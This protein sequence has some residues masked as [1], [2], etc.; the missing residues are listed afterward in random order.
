MM[1]RDWMYCIPDMLIAL[2]LGIG[3]TVILGWLLA[4]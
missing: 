1:S 3:C 4:S 2:G